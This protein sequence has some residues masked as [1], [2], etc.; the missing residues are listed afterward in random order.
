MDCL[1]TVTVTQPFQGYS[2]IL[3]GAIPET[4]Q[5][6]LSRQ[7]YSRARNCQCLQIGISSVIYKVYDIKTVKTVYYLL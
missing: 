5:D 1:C 4:F 3:F 7:H 6:H 2:C